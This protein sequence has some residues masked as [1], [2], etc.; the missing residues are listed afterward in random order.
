MKD[1][2]AP[3]LTGPSEFSQS[4]TLTVSPDVLP[5]DGASQSLVTVTARDSS[6][7]P[8]R[9]LALRAETRVGGVPVEFGSLSARSIA[10]GSDGKATLVYT[11][12]PRSPEAHLSWSTLWSRRS[13]ATSATPP[14]VAQRFDWCRT[15]RFRRR[16]PDWIRTSR[17]RLPWSTTSQSCLRRVTSR[18]G[19][20]R[21]RAIPSFPTVGTLVTEGT[22]QDGL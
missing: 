14:F 5:Q 16:Q 19:P 6:S 18:L 3:P 12:P 2:D 17:S 1:Q 8:I 10:T 20:A 4:I 11:A 7:Q 21:R 9:N 22:I 15:D 13:A